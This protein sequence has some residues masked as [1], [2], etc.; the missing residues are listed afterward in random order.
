MASLSTFVPQ[1][2]IRAGIGLITEDR[3]KTGLAL[4]LSV[5]KNTTIA[6]LD[7]YPGG[8]LNLNQ[9]KRCGAFILDLDIKTPSPHQES[10]IF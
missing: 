10:S 5:I 8:I 3:H 6:G 1:D 7:Q 2:S 4:N 9:E